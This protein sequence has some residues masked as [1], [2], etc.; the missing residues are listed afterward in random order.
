MAFLGVVIDPIIFIYNN[1]N[2]KRGVK[3]LLTKAKAK[4][5]KKSTTDS[6]ISTL[7][8]A[9]THLPTTLPRTLPRNKKWRP[10]DTQWILIE[11]WTFKLSLFSSC[12]HCI[13]DWIYTILSKIT[14]LLIWYP[15]I[16]Q[17]FQCDVNRMNIER[18]IKK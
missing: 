12:R 18:I 7:D 10:D 4:A 2:L 16:L 8:V 3:A 11:D 13:T 1:D 9:T 5:T 17:Q 14:Q 6:N 15:S